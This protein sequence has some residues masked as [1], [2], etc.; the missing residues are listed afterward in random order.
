[1]WIDKTAR[2]ATADPM[3]RQGKLKIGITQTMPA[4]LR[5]Q[6]AVAEMWFRF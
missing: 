4:F 1:M 5:R 3:L 2:V 6:D